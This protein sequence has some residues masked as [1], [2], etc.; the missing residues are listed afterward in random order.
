MDSHIELALNVMWLA[1]IAV[2]LG[3]MFFAKRGQEV[4]L[5]ATRLTRLVALIIGY[6]LV[7][8]S[9]LSY[10]VLGER[11]IA[12]TLTVALVG[13]GI[14]FV[15]IATAIWARL[16]LGRNWSSNVD[17]KAGHELIRSGPYAAVRHPIYSG[18]LQALA[19]TG[20][21]IGQWRCVA[22]FVIVLAVY[23]WKARSEE[24]KLAAQ[25]GDAW[26]EHMK[27]TGFLVPWV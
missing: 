15:G 7:F 22:G 25:F 3:T 13:T 5:P 20:L 27:R 2:W 6:S 19:G 21:V 24:A 9:R 26:T 10:G 4:E 11:F 12:T 17:I 18:I 14:T 23:A 8:T 1:L 16:I